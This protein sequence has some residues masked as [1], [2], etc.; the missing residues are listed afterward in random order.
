VVPEG[1]E[2]ARRFRFAHL[3]LLIGLVAV[4][5]SASGRAA[6]E[7]A[8]VYAFLADNT[9]VRTNANLGTWQVVR[10]GKEPPEIISTGQVLAHSRDRRV[11]WALVR[12]EGT[13]VALSRDLRVRKVI[14]L[15]ATWSARAISVGPKTGRLYIAYNVETVKRGRHDP[16]RAA[17][18]AIF[19]TDG[20]RRLS[21][22]LLR[23]N[24]GRSWLV[25]SLALDPAERRAYV[26]YHGS[27]TTGLDVARIDGAKIVNCKL[28]SRPWTGCWP[29]P[30]G[31]VVAGEDDVVAT[32]GSPVVE[33]YD[34]D[35]A[36]IRELDTGLEGNHLMSVELDRAG[37]RLFATGSCGY[38]PG[39]A[40][41]ELSTGDRRLLTHSRST[42]AESLAFAGGDVV[43]AGKTALPVP[44]P[45]REGQ[46]LRIDAEHGTVTGSHRA[47]S[48]PTD[49]LV[50]R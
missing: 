35:G 38:V 21:D 36:L 39:F 33:V 37:D 17:R 12:S 6:A 31:Q 27:D 47:P 43:I 11:V 4:L 42:C 45:Y 32:T 44:A 46:L 8:A 5:A 3:S 15:R 49:V 1:E 40:V 2:F 50:V 16:L 29:H 19:T 22:T 13:L 10:V 48:D 30:H 7:P 41:V 20:S 26:S 28:R 24:G 14:R 23:P 18:L 9:V 34:L 25:W